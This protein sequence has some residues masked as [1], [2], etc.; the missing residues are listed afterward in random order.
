H[1]RKGL[2]RLFLGSF[3]E[4][5]LTDSKVPVLL[6]GREM[7]EFRGFQ[8]ILFPTDFGPT[9]RSQ[10]NR[11]VQL[12]ASLD[13]DLTLFHVIQ[14]P[15]EPAW[16]ELYPPEPLDYLSDYIQ[17][18]TELARQRAE[19]WVRIAEARGVPMEVHVDSRGAAGTWE[20]ITTYARKNDVGLIA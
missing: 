3:A 15:I 20:Q 9:S 14:Y 13:A 16:T 11:V 18:Q 10:L 19:S 17:T 1:S 12:A 8:H 7:K 2:K 6:I 4:N 5:L